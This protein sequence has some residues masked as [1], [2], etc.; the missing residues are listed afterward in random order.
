MMKQIIKNFILRSWQWFYLRG[1]FP[2]LNDK[3]VIFMLHRMSSPD[4]FEQGHSPEFLDRALSYLKNK[5]YNFVSLE[6]LF[7]ATE[8]KIELPKNSIAFTMDDGFDDQAEIAAPIFIK[9][10]C[11]VTVFLITNFIDTGNPPWDSL[12]KHVFINSEKDEIN[13]KVDG[14]QSHFNLSNPDERYKSLR[15]FRN[16]CKEFSQDDLNDLLSELL[17]AAGMKDISLPL[18]SARPLTWKRARELERQGVSFAPHTENHIILSKA[19]DEL[20]SQEITGAWKRIN[21]ELEYPCPVYAYPT[22]RK[23]DFTGRDVNLIRELNLKGAVT[24]EPGC[25]S[26][27][28]ATK[29][30]NYLVKRINFPSNLE[31]LIQSVSGIEFVEARLTK[32]KYNF[33]CHGK[34][35]M[36]FLFMT[37]LKSS[38]GFYNRYQQLD[39]DKVTRLVFVCKGNICR[40]PYA[41]MKVRSLGLDAISV[42]LSTIE[43]SPANANAIESAS[44]RSIKLDDHRARLANSINITKSDL[45]ICME[46]LQ[47]NQFSEINSIDC[48]LTLLGLFAS[49][50]KPVILDPYGRPGSYFDDCF[51]QIDFALHNL[52]AKWRCPKI[53]N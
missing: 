46:P 49:R 26:L 45:V 51:Q 27:D 15:D 2:G 29:A 50:K 44:Y 24:A 5:G 6:Q 30:D 36:L 4:V 17:N 10:Q 47:L 19:S 1:A 34:L 43:G 16:K 53:K 32:L 25:F 35:Y 14:E 28:E 11:P 31:D 52:L 8:G 3:A 42:G 40:S 12:V 7:D 38:L 37:Q 39:W 18:S 48:Q 13:L 21:D 33:D 23:Q 41:E 9:H 22:G 20:A